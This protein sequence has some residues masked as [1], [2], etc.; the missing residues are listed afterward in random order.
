MKAM[1]TTARSALDVRAPSAARVGRW[2][3]WLPGAA[4]ALAFGA[5]FL[6]AGVVLLTTVWQPIS[7]YAVAEIVIRN[8]V[9]HPPLSGPYSTTRGFHHPLPWVYVLMWVP[10]TLSGSRSS[11]QLM[12]S[13]WWNG[14]GVALLLWFT[15]RRQALWLGI[16]IVAA[17]ALFARST[18]LAVL[19]M[20]WNPNL[21]FIPCVILL[22][23]VWQIC[24]GSH[25]FLPL[26]AALATWC[27]GAHIGFIPVVGAVSAV[28][29]IVPV[30][31]LTRAEGRAGLRQLAWPAALAAGVVFVMVLPAIVDVALH[32]SRSNPAGLLRWFRHPHG[33]RLSHDAP[34]KALLG[35][36]AVTPSW[37]TGAQATNRGFIVRPYR[38]PVLLLPVVAAIAAAWWRRATEELVGIGLSLLALTVGFVA[39]YDIQAA[40]TMVSWFLLPMRAAL[41][42]LAGF[43][44]WSICR[45][46]GT[47]IHWRVDRRITLSRLPEVGAAAAIA[48]VLALLILP[49]FRIK[50]TDRITAR[51]ADAVTRGVE[52]H[53]SKDRPIL[54]SGEFGAD[55]YNPQTAALA[56]SRAGYSVSFPPQWAYIFGGGLATPPKRPATHLFVSRVLPNGPVHAPAGAQQLA[57]ASIAGS[58]FAPPG[59]RLVVWRLP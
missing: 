2:A 43:T 38:A 29:V 12:T 41:M 32:G 57:E 18:N 50:H 52:R 8:A 49:S 1:P 28:A 44:V 20:P 47:A 6:V 22:V 53:V 34:V 48:A 36:L 37:I 55:S 7:D 30:V 21:A 13:V 35:D 10:Y 33:A 5:V 39:L 14:A 51:A 9:H 46:I 16:A 11:A 31:R 15:A 24:L 56:L 23:V 27:A 58:Y 45:S 19:M 40:A 26:A 3:P 54:L 25:R 4:P 59:T 42:S 17:I